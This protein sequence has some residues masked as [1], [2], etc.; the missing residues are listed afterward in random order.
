MSRVDDRFRG[1]RAGGDAG[2]AS[3]AS[4]RVTSRVICSVNAAS[5]V[6][7]HAGRLDGSSH[8]PQNRHFTAAG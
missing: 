7:D 1:G 8:S 5:S 4:W 6:P 3:L 2:R